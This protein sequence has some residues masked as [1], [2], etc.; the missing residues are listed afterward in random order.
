MYY[1]PVFTIA[2]TST[3]IHCCACA[4]WRYPYASSN[5]SHSIQMLSLAL[6]FRTQLVSCTRQADRP[7]LS[8][9]WN[10]LSRNSPH[11]HAHDRTNGRLLRSTIGERALCLFAFPLP[12][13]KCP[14]TIWNCIEKSRWRYAHN[15]PNRHAHTDTHTHTIVKESSRARTVPHKRY[16]EYVRLG[17]C[18]RR[19]HNTQHTHQVME[20]HIASHWQSN[21]VRRQP[22]SM[23]RVCVRLCRT[24]L[25]FSFQ[26]QFNVRRA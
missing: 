19:R 1:N 25:C 13:S 18:R 10:C 26:F 21:D 5:C 8:E 17:R 15:P 7:E 9:S 12:R 4:P 14:S 11:I 3:S 6:C 2:S 20:K 23:S 24:T 16:T 22:S